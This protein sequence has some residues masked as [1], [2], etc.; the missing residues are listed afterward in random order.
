[1]SFSHLRSQYHL[2]FYFLENFNLNYHFL[3]VS[4]DFWL[5]SQD[6]DAAVPFFLSYSDSS[7]AG[8]GPAAGSELP[9]RPAEPVRGRRPTQRRSK[10]ETQIVGRG[11][12]GRRRRLASRSVW[13]RSL[14]NIL[15]RFTASLHDA[16]R[17]ISFFRFFVNGVCMWPFQ[18][19]W[20][21][22]RPVR[23]NSKDRASRRTPRNQRW[24]TEPPRNRCD[25][26]TLSENGGFMEKSLLFISF[27]LSSAGSPAPVWPRRAS[28]L[29]TK[30]EESWAV[31][32]RFW[33]HFR[34]HF[35]DS[36]RLKL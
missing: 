6:I 16:F 5:L 10:K 1:M 33:L 34:D 8:L 2:V 31:Q 29:Q 21:P 22:R 30:E 12:A 11:A 17:K 18:K 9:R 4:C 25:R 13:I 28:V 35:I 26:W 19:A 7:S 3:G 27:S 20:P 36:F 23:T 15:W 24:P 14:E 32:M